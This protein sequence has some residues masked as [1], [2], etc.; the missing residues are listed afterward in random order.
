M[1]L[2]LRANR[3]LADDRCPTGFCT[4]RSI[5][6]KSLAGSLPSRE[7]L[8]AGRRTSRVSRQQHRLC[9][10]SGEVLLEVRDLQAKVGAEGRQI[11][12]GV[13]LKVRAG[14]THAIM[15]T[16]GSGK[17]TLSKVLVRTRPDGNRSL[18]SALPC[19][20][21]CASRVGHKDGSTRQGSVRKCVPRRCRS[22]T[23]ITRS[24]EV[25]QRTKARTSST[26]SQRTAPV[27][28]CS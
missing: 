11:L 4:D 22:G 2:R 27:L 21:L 23:R 14:E 25:L 1:N 26:L 5:M 17:S 16:N 15:G 6:Q 18:P 9:I 24:Q 28:A 13:S 7:L 20:V 3:A 10:A 8:N 12:N 19:I